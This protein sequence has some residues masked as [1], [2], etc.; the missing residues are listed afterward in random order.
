[1]SFLRM[2]LGSITGGL[3]LFASSGGGRH[4]ESG[5]SGSE[6]ASS[7]EFPVRDDKGGVVVEQLTDVFGGLALAIG[8]PFRADRA[9]R[10]WHNELAV[11]GHP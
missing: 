3:S 4:C 2:G 9:R 1:M 8:A 11:G 7:R 10:C 6:V 5:V